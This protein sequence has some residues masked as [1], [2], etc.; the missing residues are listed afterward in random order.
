MGREIRQGLILAYMP[1]TIPEG[2]HGTMGAQQRWGCLLSPQGSGGESQWGV[3]SLDQVWD[4]RAVGRGE[5][6]LAQSG[7][8]RPTGW[9]PPGAM[10]SS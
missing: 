5:E 1:H 2:S 9:P 7:I 4:K 10:F 6:L 8:K 3:C